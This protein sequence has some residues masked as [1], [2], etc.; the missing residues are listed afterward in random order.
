MITKRRRKVEGTGFSVCGFYAN[1]YFNNVEANTGK[2]IIILDKTFLFV[3]Q[4]LL[5]TK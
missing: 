4:G 5:H 3:N 2:P 1:F